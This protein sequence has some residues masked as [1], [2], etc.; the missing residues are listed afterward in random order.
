[1]PPL[2]SS[3][4]TINTCHTAGLEDRYSPEDNRNFNKFTLLIEL[5]GEVLCEISVNYIR[6]HVKRE[7]T[8]TARR[9]DVD[10]DRL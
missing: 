6:I 8:T 10:I 2:V 3:L 5:I 9:R 4:L 7:I 1:M